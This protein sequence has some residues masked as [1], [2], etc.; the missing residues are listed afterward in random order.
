M[1]TDLTKTDQAVR[2]GPHYWVRHARPELAVS[3]NHTL[4]GRCRPFSGLPGLD[5]TD[6]HSVAPWA[7]QHTAPSA[8]WT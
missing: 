2:H 8:T 7:Q 5:V 4:A 6:E 1:A 3:V